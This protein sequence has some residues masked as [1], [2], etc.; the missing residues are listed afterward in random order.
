MRIFH[1]RKS[2]VIVE[3]PKAKTISPGD[4]V[5]EVQILSPRPVIL[6]G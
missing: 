2:A 1:T 5:P 4:R 6:I 3:G